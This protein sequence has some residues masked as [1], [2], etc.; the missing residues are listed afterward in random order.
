MWTPEPDLDLDNLPPADQLWIIA[1]AIEEAGGPS[2]YVLALRKVAEHLEEVGW[3]LTEPG[4][5]L[6]IGESRQE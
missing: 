4:R 3:W 1:L 5:V 6:E 2:E